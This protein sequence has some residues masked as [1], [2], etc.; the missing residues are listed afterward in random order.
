VVC[1]GATERETEREVE[2]GAVEPW[3]A[4]DRPPEYEV[5]TTLGLTVGSA[6]T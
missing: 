6:R 4:L 1:S 3:P 2:A 5:G